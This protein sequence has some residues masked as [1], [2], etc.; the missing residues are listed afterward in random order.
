MSIPTHYRLSTTNKV[1][2]EIFKNPQ[3]AHPIRFYLILICS[4]M[5][6]EKNTLLAEKYSMPSSPSQAQL[7]H[8]LRLSCF[9]TTTRPTKLCKWSW[10]LRKVLPWSYTEHVTTWTQGCTESKQKEGPLL[11]TRARSVWTT[12]YAEAPPFRSTKPWIAGGGRV[13]GHGP[14]YY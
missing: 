4:I 12:I 3:G 6:G 10:Q 5:L 9:L 7:L 1:S 14:T 8:W 2:P 11:C 13:L